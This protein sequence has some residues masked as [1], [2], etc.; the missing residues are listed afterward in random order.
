M[1]QNVKAHEWIQL[2]QDRFQW[3]FVNMVIN[4]WVSEKGKEFLNQLNNYQL[5]KKGSAPWN[6]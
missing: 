2:T 5:L 4:L 6:E 3:G 1:K